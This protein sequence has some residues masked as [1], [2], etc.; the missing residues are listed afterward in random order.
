MDEGSS[1]EHS[2][3]LKDRGAETGRRYRYQYACAGLFS[4]YLLLEDSEYSEIYCEHHEDIVLKYN[5]GT[6]CGIQV[7]TKEDGKFSFNDATTFDIINKFIRCDVKHNPHFKKYIIATNCGYTK[8]ENANDIDFCLSSL[9][10]GV[11]NNPLLDN[12]FFKNLVSKWETETGQSQE[13]VLDVLK[14]TYTQKVFPLERFDVSLAYNIAI[15][16]QN[17]D[18]GL[19]T[20]LDISHDLIE[21]V[22]ESSSYPCLDPRYHFLCLLENPE[23]QA[24][25]LTVQEKMITKDMV[26]E[27]FRK[28]IDP[29]VYLS[30]V[31]S[32]KIGQLSPGVHRLELKMDSGGIKAM[33]IYYH[34]SHK[35][36]SE[37]LLAK[38]YKKYGSKETNLRFQHL[39]N[40]VGNQC[41]EAYRVNYNDTEKFGENMLIDV[42]ERLKEISPEIKTTFSDCSYEHL[43][44]ISGILTQECMV[45][46][47]MEY[48]DP[49]WLKK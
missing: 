36:S 44:G 9:R 4:V 31:D 28:N 35:V 47:S 10:E 29:T 23:E 6:Y 8:T 43:L 39:S 12:P 14:K 15:L 5:D 32:K 38:W 1:P 40:K 18:Q 41:Q 49:E 20:L 21:K 19:A 30:M 22:F 24:V 11:E 27:I 33:D 2:L 46:W 7:K 45:I 13:K 16:T 3:D 25:T 17:Q 48:S 42:S 34:K 37:A 26:E